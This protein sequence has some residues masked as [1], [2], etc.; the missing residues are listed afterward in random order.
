M[1]LSRKLRKRFYYTIPEAGAQVAFSRAEAYRAAD[2]GDIP[3]EKDGRLRL[4]PR[5]RWDR[6]RKQILRGS[7]LKTRPDRAAPAGAPTESA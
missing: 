6:L 1:R 4:V 5:K 7:L 3:T 2:R